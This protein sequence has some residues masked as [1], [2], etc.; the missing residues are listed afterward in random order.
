M[1]TLKERQEELYQEQRQEEKRA[2]ARAARATEYARDWSSY[3]KGRNLFFYARSQGDE[4]TLLRY[5]IT[6]DPE[7]LLSFT[8]TDDGF[9]HSSKVLTEGDVLKMVLEAFECL[10]EERTE[11]ESSPD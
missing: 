5:G 10:P 2:E 9:K 3:C 7:P 6:E 8:I 4:I 11:L 1:K